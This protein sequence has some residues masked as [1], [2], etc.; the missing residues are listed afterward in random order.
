MWR[1]A[2]EAKIPSQMEARYLNLNS[3]LDL[4]NVHGV[5]FRPNY[6]QI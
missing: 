3:G 6:S 5:V 2:E 1:T 4:E